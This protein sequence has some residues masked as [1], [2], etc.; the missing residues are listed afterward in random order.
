M[1]GSPASPRGAE[2]DERGERVAAWSLFS[3]LKDGLSGADGPPKLEAYALNL[4]GK[5]PIYKDFINVGVHRGGD[6]GLPRLARERLQPALVARRR[7]Q[8]DRDPPP[9]VPLRASRREAVGR[10]CPLGEPR[11][12]G[13][14]PVP[15]H[16]LLGRPAGAADR[17]TLRRPLLPRAVRGARDLHPAEL[18][19]GPHGRVVL[20]ELPRRPDRAGR[21]EAGED[22]R[23]CREGG[24][25]R[26]PGRLRRVAPRGPARPRSGRASSP[27]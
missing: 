14:S 1:P 5:L 25:S 22:R 27:G 4:H 20:R 12:G 16:A 26:H 24:E 13:A 11:R 3:K 23:G 8:G 10:G 2:A 17:G 7:L 9:H 15:L 6:E 19:A 18:L 21:E